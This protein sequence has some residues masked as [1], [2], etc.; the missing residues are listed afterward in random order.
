MRSISSNLAH[1]RLWTEKGVW[2]RM[3]PQAASV[4]KMVQVMRT[5]FLLLESHGSRKL[6]KARPWLTPVTEEISQLHLP[7]STILLFL[8]FTALLLGQ[9]SVTHDRVSF[10][11]SLLFLFDLKKNYFSYLVFL[12]VLGFCCCGRTFS[13]VVVH[14]LLIVAISSAGYSAW[15]Q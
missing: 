15:A 10:S 1:P 2:S 3:L 5:S 14:G 7:T 4:F 8:K 13:L 11:K 6:T 9:Q 12:A